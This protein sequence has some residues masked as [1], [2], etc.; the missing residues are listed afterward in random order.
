MPKAPRHRLLSKFGFAAVSAPAST[1]AAPRA[2]IIPDD[3]DVD[4]D[5]DN[6]LPARQPAAQVAPSDVTGSG[7]DL[8]FALSR[9]PG[10]VATEVAA[11]QLRWQRGPRRPAPSWPD[12]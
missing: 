1:S 5:D 11:S 10:L 6:L 7:R 9:A 12:S 8:A 3:T 4:A 2:T